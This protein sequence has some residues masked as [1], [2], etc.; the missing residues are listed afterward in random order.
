MKKLKVLITGASGMVGR[1]LLSH[2]RSN[3]FQVLSPK[4]SDL[5]LLNQ[6]VVQ[7]Y[8]MA[9][10]PDF[11]IHAAGKVGGIQANIQNPVEFLLHNLDM[12]RNLIVAAQQAGISNIIN[13]G[14]SCMYP[15]NI[16]TALTEDLILKGELEPTNEGYA[17]AKIAVSKLCE[18]ISRQ[19]EKFRFKTVIPCN[20]YGPFDKFNPENSHLIPSIIYKIHQAI[21]NDSDTVEI[22][23][24]GQ[25]RREFMYA[26]DLAD[27][28]WRGVENF[29]AL[30]NIMNIGLGFDYTINEYYQMT[31]KIMGYRGKFIH[32]LNKPV[33]MNRKLVDIAKQK[34]LGWC[35]STS[36]EDGL[37]KTY[38][39]F[40]EEVLK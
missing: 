37:T 16:Q 27:A 40:V 23:G 18:Y 2:A 33:G 14:S 7:K 32:N 24:D 31:A 1:N 9:E 29:D 19:D 20:L 3:L 11:I 21:F 39:H 12:G 5:D 15:R 22:W 8:L 38:K 28:I 13:L 36:L 34:K 30:P 4:R 6:S 10:K 25:A 26:P 35:A 17:I